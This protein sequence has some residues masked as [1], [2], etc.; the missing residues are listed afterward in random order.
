MQF[1]SETP[2]YSYEVHRE[3]GEDVLYIN[4]LGAPYVPSLSDSAEVMDILSKGEKLLHEKKY[5]EA[6]EFFNNALSV[7]NK[8]YLSEEMDKEVSK[9]KDYIYQ[10]ELKQIIVKGDFS[11]KEE[12]FI[13]EIEK[14][15]G[16]SVALIGTG[17]DALEIVDR[18][19]NP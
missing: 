2:L 15:V 11:E 8:M 18:G 10:T 7:T 9:I 13:E 4:Y 19:K 14:K 17:P 12:K 1:K 5:N 16:L 3:G 6:M